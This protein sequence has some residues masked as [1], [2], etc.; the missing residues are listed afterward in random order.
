MAELLDRLRGLGWTAHGQTPHKTV[1]RDLRCGTRGGT[2][3]IRV[4][5]AWSDDDTHV[6]VQGRRYTSAWRPGPAQGGGV[7]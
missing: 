4:T 7:E 6:Y 3:V 2:D 1:R 5:G